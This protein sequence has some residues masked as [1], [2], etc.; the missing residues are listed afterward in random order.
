VVLMGAAK[1]ALAVT[2]AQARVVGRAV[3]WGGSRGLVEAA[4]VVGRVVLLA[5]ALWEG[6]MVRAALMVAR[7]AVEVMMVVG[8]LVVA[9]G[10]RVE[11]SG[12]ERC[13]RCEQLG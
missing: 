2:V 3:A 9:V 7:K 8:L 5:A 1:E 6:G 4:M 12:G 13:I 10:E 11:R